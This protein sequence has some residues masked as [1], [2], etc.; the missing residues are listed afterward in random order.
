MRK[1]G[2]IVRDIQSC[3][4]IDKALQSYTAE[5]A[6]VGLSTVWIESVF[7]NKRPLTVLDASFDVHGTGVNILD[8]MGIAPATQ[9][10]MW[11][12]LET[13]LY[14][15]NYTIIH[16]LHTCACVVGVIGACSTKDFSVIAFVACWLWRRSCVFG[17]KSSVVDALCLPQR[18]TLRLRVVLSQNLK[19]DHVLLYH[20][21]KTS[22][23]ALLHG[24]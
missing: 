15:S 18:L 6:S 16:N 2:E 19:S 1:A 12:K 20:S 22:W 13:F 14:C 8:T 5:A 7:N 4:D 21:H 3:P 9:K 11:D 17:D 24:E 23:H 10:S